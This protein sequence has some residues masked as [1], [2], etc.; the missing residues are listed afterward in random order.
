MRYASS[1]VQVG[2][3][4]GGIVASRLRVGYDGSHEMQ[5]MKKSGTMP[6][7]AVLAILSFMVGAMSWW[8][9]TYWKSLRRGIRMSVVTTRSD[10]VD[11]V[12]TL[13]TVTNTGSFS[14]EY[15]VVL[16]FVT[17]EENNPLSCS[18]LRLTGI[19]PLETYELERETPWEGL[20]SWAFVY[21]IE[22]MDARESIELEL[23]SRYSLIATRAIATSSEISASY[24]N[25]VLRGVMVPDGR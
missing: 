3:V 11:D 2:S 21:T 10:H 19:Q 20:R 5:R 16:I 15:V 9:I 7:Y 13:V 14:E 8:L 1:A 6:L 12:R 23:R 17:V 22:D 25:P 4:M 18:I 24:S